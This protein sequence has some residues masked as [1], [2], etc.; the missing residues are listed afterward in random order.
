M[1]GPVPACSLRFLFENAAL[2]SDRMRC[3]GDER[4]RL[5]KSTS[6]SNT[7]RL[8][9]TTD[10]VKNTKEPDFVKMQGN[11][12]PHVIHANLQ[13]ILRPKLQGSCQYMVYQIYA[14]KSRACCADGMGKISQ[15][16]A[17][18]LFPDV[19]AYPVSRQEYGR[20]STIQM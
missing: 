8:T 3:Q 19:F 9:E 17:S 13:D 15:K 20:P 12:T 1:M 4:V 14:V 18:I 16:T 10:S 5:Q 11:R 6:Q 7:T 2:C